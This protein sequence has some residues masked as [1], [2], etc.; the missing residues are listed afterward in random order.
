MGTCIQDET[1]QCL[2]G[3]SGANCEYVEC[4]G[5]TNEPGNEVCS[6]HGQCSSPDNC[7]CDSGYYGSTCSITTCFEK[8]SN[9]SNSNNICSG[10]G[11]CSS[12]DV[13]EC[14]AGYFGSE[15]EKDLF[16]G[17]KLISIS[18]V[19]IAKNSPDNVELKASIALPSMVLSSAY[20]HDG[21]QPLPFVVSNSTTSIVITDTVN[22]AFGQLLVQEADRKA[23]EL[24]N[25]PCDFNISNPDQELNSLTIIRNGGVYCFPN[26][27]TIRGHTFIIV[28]TETVLF[29]SPFVYYYGASFYYLECASYRN[30]F[31]LTY[32][33]GDN[34]NFFSG[35]IH[36]TVI[37]ISPYHG[38]QLY[39]N[40]VGAVWYTG[41][42]DMILFD[43]NILPPITFN[44][45]ESFSRDD[46][47][48]TSCYGI[49]FR[50]NNTC[51]GRGHC[52]KNDTCLCNTDSYGSNCLISICNGVYGNETNVC[53]GHGECQSKDSCECESG[54][55]GNWCE[56]TTCF[57]VQNDQPNTCNGHGLCSKLDTCEC[58]SGF[59]YGGS[60]CEIPICN[61]TM[62]NESSVCLSRGHCVQPNMCS[63][64]S[65]YSGSNCEIANCFGIISNDSSVCSGH[66]SCNSVDTCTCSI[67]YYGADCS[68]FDCYGIQSVNSS[69]C[70]GRG[71]C[72]NVNT[73]SCSQG[74]YGNECE[75]SM[76]DG[77]LGNS[78]Q[79]CSSYGQCKDTDV[80]DCQLGY[81]GVFCNETTC[82]SIAM[83]DSTVCNGQG[84]C[85]PLDTCVCSN[86]YDGSNCQNPICFGI[87][88]TNTS[89]CG[90]HG[91][92]SQPNIC[93]CNQGYYGSQCEIVTCSGIMSNGSTVCSGQGQCSDMDIC[94]CN[95]HYYGSNCEKFDCF[96]VSSLLNTSCSGHGT[97]LDYNTCQCYS[98]YY[99]NNCDVTKCY[100]IFSNSSNVCSSKGSCHVRDTCICSNN[101]HGSYCNITSCNGVYSNDASVCSGHG[102]CIGYDT[103]QCL[104]DYSGSNCQGEIVDPFAGFR[105]ISDSSVSISIDYFLTDW[106]PVLQS[107]TRYYAS[108]L[109]LK[110]ISYL[111]SNIQ[112]L[113]HS[114]AVIL[115]STSAQGINI[116]N[117]MKTIKSQLLAS[118]T[119]TKTYTNTNSP[120]TFIIK[121]GGVICF[122]GGMTF[123]PERTI[124]I[125]GTEPVIFKLPSL[126]YS[127]LNIVFL[128]CAS[129]RN[130]FW[131]LDSNSFIK[132]ADKTKNYQP[133]IHGTFIQLSGTIS[134]RGYLAGSVC[135]SNINTLLHEVT[136]YDPTTFDP[137]QSVTSQCNYTLCYNIL[138][139]NQSVCS[140][141]GNCSDYNTC[142]CNT[143]SYGSD[144]SLF[145]CNGILSSN[146]TFVCN[147]RGKCVGPDVCS[148]NPG[149]YGDF[150]ELT[151]CNG[152][153]NTSPLVCNGRGACNH[154]N[155][156]SCSSTFGYG[157]SD[158]DIPICYQKLATNRL[159]CSSRGDCLGPNVCNCTE[160]YLGDNCQLTTCADILSNSSL[161]CSGFGS[162]VGYNNCTCHTGFYGE[163]CAEYDCFGVNKNN[164]NVCS[165][166]GECITVNNCT[167]QDG[168][169]GNNC[170]YT[171]CFGVRSDSPTV[172]NSKGSCRAK[173]VCE[174]WNGYFGSNCTLTSCGGIYSNDSSVCNGHG[175]CWPAETC[176]CLSQY[177]YTGQLCEIPICYT[178][179]A[180]DPLTCSSHGSCVGVNTCECQANYTGSKC[181]VTSC[182]GI[183]SNGSL[184]CSGHG[185]C[186][187]HDNCTCLAGYFDTACNQFTCNGTN[188]QDSS[189]CSG[190][191]SCDSYNNCSCQAGYYGPNCEKTMCNNILS[192]NPS[193][194][195]SRGNCIAP[196]VCSCNE[197]YFGTNCELTTCN[198]T[199][200]NSSSVCSGSGVCWPFDTC[201]CYSDLVREFEGQWCEKRLWD[202]FAGYRMVSH[203]GLVYHFD[204]NNNFYTPDIHT[205]TRYYRSSMILDILTK[206]TPT[207][208]YT[209]D[210]GAH[211]D[212]VNTPKASALAALM[213]KKGNSM[214]TLPCTKT[215]NNSSDLPWIS[216]SE[217][218]IRHGGVFCFNI[219]A[220]F[221]NNITIIIVGAE[222]VVMKVPSIQYSAVNFVFA[223]C[224]S[225]R[226][227]FWFIT[228]YNPSFI[229]GGN[230]GTG[231][232][233]PIYGTFFP[234]S[235]GSFQLAGPFAGSVW[236][237][238]NA[239]TV[240][241]DVTVY[242]P[243]ST[244]P[245]EPTVGQFCNYTQCFNV[246]SN[247][248]TTCSGRGQ[249][250]DYNTCVCN[251]DA[252]GVDCSISKCNGTF[253]NVS[254]VCNGHGSCIAKDTCQCNTGY[255]GEWCQYTTCGGIES[256]SPLTCRER[257]TCIAYN[258]CSCNVTKGYNGNDC[259]IPY[260]NNILGNTSTVCSAH[261][262]C[263]LPN[264]CNCSA[265]YF[266]TFCQYTTCAGIETY[267]S[268]VCIGRG[269][270]TLYNNC[271]CNSPYYGSNCEQFKCFGVNNNS[272]TVCSGRGICTDYNTCVCN[273]GYLGSNCEI[274]SCFGI[275]SNV[276]LV[277]KAHGVCVA[278]NTCVCA[279]NYM[280]SDCSVTSCSG[281]N[282][283]WSS[284]C[285]GR[286]S[287]WPYNTCNCNAKLGYT[288]NDCNEPMCDG[289]TNSDPYV[290]SGRGGT[291]VSPNLC[292]CND[293]SKY[294]GKLC[295]YTYCRGVPTNLTDTALFCSGNG[296]CTDYNYCYCFSGYTGTE[297]ELDMFAGYRF[298]TNKNVYVLKNQIYYLP[299][300]IAIGP[301]LSAAGQ[302]TYLPY[303]QAVKTNLRVDATL[304]NELQMRAMGLRY[305][306]FPCEHYIKDASVFGKN[307]ELRGGVYC[308][309]NPWTIDGHN[310]TV[311]GKKRT[312]FTLP[313]LIYKSAKF[314]YYE[315]AS[316][317]DVIFYA[318]E[319]TGYSNFTG[320]IDAT[321]FVNSPGAA[322][323][324]VNGDINGAIYIFGKLGSNDAPPTGT[325]YTTD[326]KFIAPYTFDPAVR[327][328]ESK[329]NYF[330][331][332][333]IGS[334]INTTCSG[335]GK[336]IGIDTCSCIS[337]AYGP[338][339][340]LRMCNGTL[341]NFSNVCSGHGS[342]ISTDICQCNAGFYGQ[343]CQ[344]TKCYGLE[345]TSP[346]VCSG[347]GSCLSENN[348]ICNSTYGYEGSQCE[349][350]ICGGQLGICASSS[351]G[352]CTAPDTC[353]CL[354]HYS[355]QFCQWTTCNSVPSNSSSVCSGRGICAAYNTCQCK[356][357]YIG[358]ICEKDVFAGYKLI[359]NKAVLL[360][361]NS[362]ASSVLA[363]SIALPS[364]TIRPPTF[365]NPDKVYPYVAS[366]KSVIT[367]PTDSYYQTLMTEL[368]KKFDELMSAP[369]D[370]VISK[371]DTE[372]GQKILI[373]HGGVYCFQNGWNI[374]GQK[375][376]I[377]GTEPV[378]FKAPYIK[379]SGANFVYLKCASYRNV[380]WVTQYY[381]LTGRVNWVNSNSFSGTV[382]GTIV[383][384]YGYD[385]LVS[386]DIQGAIWFYTQED[387]YITLKDAKLTTPPTF[388]P[389]MPY[390]TG[391]CD[392]YTCFGID[393]TSNMSCSGRG[394]CK[395]Y[396]TC[397]CQDD[398]YGIDCSIS[399]CYGIFGNVSI[400]CSSHGNCTSKDT[401][402]CSEGYFGDLCQYTSCAGIP[403]NSTNVCNQR[404]VCNIYNSCTCNTTLGYDGSNC[405]VPIC[406]H[407]VGTCTDLFRGNC[408]APNACSCENHY[409]GPWCEKT[410]CGGFESTNTQSVCNG[411]GNCTA[412]EKCTCLHG[413]AG[414]FCEEYSCFGVVRTL[415]ST[416]SGRGACSSIDQCDCSANY[417]GSNCEISKCNGKFGNES[418]VCS[419]NGQCIETNIC[420]CSEHY[421]GNWC[422][423]T[424]CFGVASNESNVCSHRGQCKAFNTCQCN[425]NYFGDNCELTTCNN[426][427]SN[428]GL[429]CNLVGNC[430]DYNTCVCPYGYTGSWCEQTTC[431]GVATSSPS[432]CNGHG[433]CTTMD[434]C[435]CDPKYGYGGSNCNITTCD[436]ELSTSS[437]CN[438]SEN[439]HGEWCELTTCNGI[440]S[441]STEACSGRGR[442]VDYNSCV[443]SNGYYGDDC[444]D[445]NCY[446]ISHFSNLTCSGYGN[447]SDI[448][449]CECFEDSIGL[450]CSVNVC[451][452][453]PM[454]SSLVCSGLGSC[455][456]PNYCN[457]SDNYFGSNCEWTTCYSIA[458]FSPSTCSGRGNCSDFDKC[459]CNSDTFGSDCSLFKCNHTLGNETQVCSG[460]G[461]CIGTDE[462]NC[463]ENYH[464]EFCE[465]TECFSQLSNES[466]VCSGK[467]KCIEF[468]NCSCQ[469]GYFDQDC[470]QF[471]CNDTFSNE[472][473]VCSSRG[474]CID[475]NKCNCSE[476]YFGLNCELSICFTI[477]SNDS[478]VCS[479]RGI[480]VDYQNCSCYDGFYGESCEF[481]V[482]AVN[483]QSNSTQLNNQTIDSSNVTMNNNSSVVF[484][485]T[486]NSTNTDN[487]S[488]VVTNHTISED[489][490]TRSNSNGTVYN[491]NSTDLSNETIS[492]NGT[493]S[494]NANVTIPDNST[495]STNQTVSP[496]TD[497]SNGTVSNNTVNATASDNTTTDNSNITI[498]D[499]TTSPGSNNQTI[500][501]SVDSSNGTISNNTNPSVV[502]NSSTVSNSSFTNGTVSNSTVTSNSSTITYNTTISSNETI[503][504]NVTSNTSKITNSTSI[505]NETVPVMPEPDVVVA[506]PVAIIKRMSSNVFSSCDDIR[507]DGSQSFSQD[508]TY[509][510]YYWNLLEASSLT[511]LQSLP[512]SPIIV[513][514]STLK[515]G[516][517]VVSLKVGNG[518]NS[519]VNYSKPFTKSAN[520]LPKIYIA[521][522]L[523]EKYGNQF[524][525][526]IKKVITESTCQKEKSVISWSQLSGPTVKYSIDSFSNLAIASLTT[527]G[528][529][530]YIFQVSAHY[531]SNPLERVSAN[532]TLVTKSP[533]LQLELLT[534]D[535]NS[536]YT[537]IVI[538]YT[539]PESAYNTLSEEWKWTCLNNTNPSLIS[540]LELISKNK[541]TEVR[542]DGS[543]LF[544][545][546][547]PRSI[548]LSLRI[549][550]SDRTISKSI[551]VYFGLVPPIV[552]IISVEPSTLYVLPGEPLSIQTLVTKGNVNVTLNGQV[553][554]VSDQQPTLD[555]DTKLLEQGSENTIT[556]T[557][558]DPVTGMSSSS[559]Y[560]F[561]VATYPKP[562]A[563][564]ISPLSG[565]ALESDFEFYCTN[566]KNSENNIDYRYGFIDDRSE[567]RILLFDSGEIY[568]SKLPSPFSGNTVKC[569][570]DIVD[571]ETG[572]FTTVYKNV[573]IEKPLVTKVE[574]VQ[575]LVESW[576]IVGS[577]YFSNG[578]FSKSIY[579]C[580]STSRTD[581][582]L[583]RQILGN[584]YLERS[585]SIE[586]ENGVDI[587]GV[588][589]C[590]DGYIGKH[591]D[592]AI[593]DFS[594]IQGT[595]LQVLREMV[596]IANSTGE[597]NNQYL[598][599]LSFA[600]DS[601]LVNYQYLDT[602]TISESMYTLNMFLEYS[603][604]DESLR[605]PT[606]VDKL[607]ESSQYSTFNYITDKQ[608]LTDQTSNALKLLKSLK[609]SSQLQARSVS[610]SNAKRNIKGSFFSIVLGKSLLADHQ[611]NIQDPHS[612][613]SIS[614]EN[615][616]FAYTARSKV[617]SIKKPYIYI[618]SVTDDIYSLGTKLKVVEKNNNVQKVS[619]LVS[620][621]VSVD[622]VDVATT[623]NPTKIIYSI[624]IN[625]NG[626]T[627]ELRRGTFDLSVKTLDQYCKNFDEGSIKVLSD[628]TLI[629]LT[630]THAKC[631]CSK[632]TNV[633][634]IETTTIST[635]SYTY[636]AA[637]GFSLV[638]VCSI[639]TLVI[640]SVCVWWKFKKP[641][642]SKKRSLVFTDASENEI[643]LRIQE[644][645]LGDHTYSNSETNSDD[646]LIIDVI[647]DCPSG[648]SS[649]TGSNNGR[650]RSYSMQ[651]RPTTMMSSS[652]PR[653][654]VGANILSSSPRGTRNRSSSVAPL[655]IQESHELDS[656]AS[657]SDEL[658]K[659]H[660]EGGVKRS[661]SGIW[662][663]REDGFL[664]HE[665][666]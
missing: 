610:M 543:S 530:T 185:S 400:V 83:N 11:T 564:F 23:G 63:C 114:S 170:S 132:G 316:Y 232:E 297:C 282:S 226:N 532:V 42:T 188:S 6:R 34:G 21:S 380:F 218:M 470:S 109:L 66:G 590:H 570:F 585:E 645:I 4:F 541:Q 449:T 335:K 529:H 515:P 196:E 654:G 47:M 221:H 190:K 142:V 16:A 660:S 173:D 361:K 252:Y 82:N 295:E 338:D 61:G 441:N 544:R 176:T 304:L 387:G 558:T 312:I 181:Q 542:F 396:N 351:R 403:N 597:M 186:I 648:G 222:P 159:V 598:S 516:Q 177:G 405:H 428:S 12:L 268:S 453:L 38:I 107:Y 274:S 348:C 313:Q 473:T 161:V 435:S 178:I 20:S 455:T 203:N 601:I 136:F 285:H 146:S 22:D 160:T 310:F 448:D 482:S 404:G 494:A 135:A 44:S 379:Y 322:D 74:Y 273:A 343:W 568:A 491:N 538:G 324:Y 151:T 467:G 71:Q 651:E 292:V 613:S 421:Y 476:N 138:S 485:N 662:D 643:Q 78:S 369:C 560:T 456:R 171:T 237:T 417:Y 127:A 308:I 122:T 454:N 475:S 512:N 53:S 140:G 214:W 432:V 633:F 639:G 72:I 393:P 228:S 607:L 56:L 153:E 110:S 418:T 143:D 434:M 27:V 618:L 147:G 629:S 658:L 238:G 119:C 68:Q 263:E 477:L 468:N 571:T 18:P 241:I 305:N 386:D 506:L 594:N 195:T 320:P 479:R 189:V 360:A 129:Y 289:L 576:T 556:I 632:F 623:M 37:G 615:G 484:N 659:N 507:V 420:N 565:I 579:Q 371:P 619:N 14:N 130:F 50:L 649:G 591:C 333:G 554:E 646:S 242:P 416:C 514:D 108:S 557:S 198:G 599:L 385:Y 5:V 311:I 291:C 261:G 563:C 408:T 192:D 458:S 346:T 166:K 206:I 635:Y 548:E 534:T 424:T 300:N 262:S 298:V 97:C 93:Q 233:P 378:I 59:G 535:A 290:C 384:R 354:D 28:G 426:L 376:T 357:G 439:Y 634:V 526:T 474:F 85:W 330:T 287:C 339:C 149:Y 427:A 179:A 631:Q 89:V 199:V 163:T 562:C 327:Y 202:P 323:Y 411:R 522:S 73:C 35:D 390:V 219:E 283:T 62:A 205:N 381:N 115:N 523:I 88:S 309:Q 197:T 230:R 303:Q 253:S 392:T 139:N 43:V 442:C 617:S 584:E 15:C 517:Y 96:G 527:Y 502:S 318:G 582:V 592:K 625:L 490:T 389:Y 154:F 65:S 595:K 266:G 175:S 359:S 377:V 581:S 204:D 664:E 573:T 397:T 183:L 302:K 525:V 609:L 509:L 358:S 350:P 486:D 169:L 611:N 395:D 505:L 488:V 373:E 492:N 663:L 345:N 191:G 79:V 459:I 349:T 294:F 518:R 19:V 211:I 606:G 165:S 39:D 99:G 436:G 209:S 388:D 103:C 90:G 301:M 481:A 246:K 616:F 278:T 519:S 375:F 332:F 462:C 559:S 355:G 172:C 661:G 550:K 647:D 248:N 636:L 296:I 144:C 225:Y 398:S 249:C 280:S 372:M 194:C 251:A 561:K 431:F 269:Q 236:V 184:V 419:S 451:N 528:F 45:N 511:S 540:F 329:C 116:V 58:A 341:G 260:C 158:C 583:L 224:A 589:K 317:R 580:A 321:I 567:T 200:S 272:S 10:H 277:C 401:C 588:C 106:Q 328:I 650:M 7:Q 370:Y 104:S 120:N 131:I 54:Y 450:D 8:W 666:F 293:P 608:Y 337:G 258:Q 95:N 510:D 546:N 41:G 60:S 586:C 100:G 422:E 496:S 433:N 499:N 447:C 157:G 644:I 215:V 150:C 31:W 656:N 551:I 265:N 445:Y 363:A 429:A 217:I 52:V 655:I 483:N 365:L 504:V 36:G 69:V 234:T 572:A 547:I 155:S 364:M 344:Y 264:T 444:Q 123:G 124:I 306:F 480:C 409:Y 638:A 84:T 244:D 602:N 549:S 25:L 125:V 489:N 640:L 70:Y 443:C 235:G 630:A 331:C 464:G 545:Q 231:Y 466:S 653:G 3:Y 270:C 81:F 336:C 508:S 94:Q 440:D 314:T 48:E 281:I 665:K 641:K 126:Q 208:N 223:E 51:F 539:D 26:G 117:K 587:S 77:I 414:A 637:I 105:I 187:E 101:Y 533:E 111:D 531:P 524:P 55:Y 180:S 210:N 286:G 446:G 452:G 537:T 141:K 461:S 460:R 566:C 239:W 227:L 164:P 412:Y 463:T 394:V 91:V 552:N 402:T 391:S 577:N 168:F 87:V 167:C 657:S 399:K 495:S 247:L 193:V 624:P 600:I 9:L 501:P 574:Q 145:K 13:C 553:V 383:A 652:S 362:R 374:N 382:H 17:Y 98:D 342:C 243:L 325:V 366:G 413:Y 86:G 326:M 407:L 620:P 128:E 593:S 642:L 271:T 67:E 605:L 368:S 212:S 430:T 245:Y 275:L 46:C 340:S 113:P 80:C 102:S 521:N 152:I 352:N 256:T 267:N 64:Q 469:D 626:S 438:C 299:A 353:S 92:C 410:T 487:S 288:G 207:L 415:P 250:I 307:I 604:S 162:C 614:M 118:L 513:I 213:K 33:Q 621:I 24:Y 457:C 255:Y 520:P 137:F 182:Q 612:S 30:V 423:K 367:K 220:S 76:C 57:G 49:S 40:L 259:E 121:H 536:N 32:D 437:Q 29:K 134:L 578:D 334:N 257:G 276:S 229:Q 174:C 628:C 201:T 603:L 216:K 500:S 478:R 240:F 498:S 406:N 425:Q 497:S 472:T 75:I 279:A 493:V 148:C 622:F 356:A 347:R 1:C 575:G 569:F 465:F 555:V 315:C 2:N 503:S 133:P 254:T 471:Q 112:Y 627:F 319:T 596:T 284:V 156:C